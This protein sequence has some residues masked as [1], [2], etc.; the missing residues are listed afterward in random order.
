L[1]IRIDLIEIVHVF[2]AAFYVSFADI[3]DV[4]R[5]LARERPETVTFLGEPS[6]HKENQRG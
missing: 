4:A 1:E 3:C 2:S 5:K 6:P